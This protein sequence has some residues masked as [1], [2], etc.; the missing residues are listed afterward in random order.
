MVVSLVLEVLSNMFSLL[1]INEQGDN[2]ALIP[3]YKKGE[4]GVIRILNLDWWGRRLAELKIC[5]V[6]FMCSACRGSMVKYKTFLSLI[7]DEECLKHHVFVSAASLLIIFAEIRTE[8]GRL[9]ASQGASGLARRTKAGSA[10]GLWLAWA[11]CG[12]KSERGEEVA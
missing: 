7:S 5:N 3:Q 4:E 10:S 1:G 9:L 8:G 12:E 11:G 2:I 6:I